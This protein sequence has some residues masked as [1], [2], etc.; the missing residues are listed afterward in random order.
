MKKESAQLN[1]HSSDMNVG[2]L[3]SGNVNLNNINANNLSNNSVN[4][5]FASSL[6]N[7]TTINTAQ[8]HN[9]TAIVKKKKKKKIEKEKKPK[10]KPGK[11]ELLKHV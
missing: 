2:V 9:N 11:T 10:P 3:Q 7:L 1:V 5:S 6:N 8:L 4:S